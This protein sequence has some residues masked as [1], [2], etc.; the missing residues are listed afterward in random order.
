MK[1]KSITGRNLNFFIKNR[2]IIVRS[3]AEFELFLMKTARFHLKKG[4]R[5]DYAF[6]TKYSLNTIPATISVNPI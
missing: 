2:P 3:R 6:F 1:G 5:G 4:V